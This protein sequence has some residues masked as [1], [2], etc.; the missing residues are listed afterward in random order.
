MNYNKILIKISYF[1]NLFHICRHSNKYVPNIFCML[2]YVFLNKVNLVIFDFEMTSFSYYSFIRGGQASAGCSVHSSVS[3]LIKIVFIRSS[4]NLVR[5]C[6]QTI[7]RSS[8]N[9]G[10]PRSKTRSGGHLM[11]FKDLASA[12]LVKQFS[13]DLLKI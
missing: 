5:S 13:S 9:M 1:H 12:F 6:I 8:K 3:S 2:S 4:Q 10:L 7:S 11:H